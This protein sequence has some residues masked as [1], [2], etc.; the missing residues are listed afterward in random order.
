MKQSYS[1]VIYEYK[2]YFNL[3]FNHIYRYMNCRIEKTGRSE[4]TNNKK[5]AKYGRGHKFD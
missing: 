4:V 2:K 5:E 3:N 1:I